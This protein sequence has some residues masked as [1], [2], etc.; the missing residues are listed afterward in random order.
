MSAAAKSPYQYSGWLK[1]NQQVIKIVAKNSF[2]NVP[3]MNTNMGQT[4]K[5]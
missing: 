4:H 2:S 1:H 5:S 3:T